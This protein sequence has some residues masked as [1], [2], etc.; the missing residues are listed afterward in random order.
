MKSVRLRFSGDHSGGRQ[1]R[2]LKAAILSS[3]LP[4][5]D[6]LGDRRIVIKTALCCTVLYCS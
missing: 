2:V 3:C 1:R 5:D 4:H 6:C